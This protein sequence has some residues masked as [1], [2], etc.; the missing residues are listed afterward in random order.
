MNVFSFR[1]VARAVLATIF[2]AVL[3]TGCENTA[4]PAAKRP[5][6]PVIGVFL[7]KD[8]DVYISMVRTA[9][10]QAL[11]DWA[12]IILCAAQSDQLL[13]NEQIDRLL[14]E[15]MDGLLVNLVDI[16]AASFVVDKAKKRGVPVVFFN[17]E[18]DPAAIKVYDKACFVGTTPADAGKMQ[19]DIIKRL[20][21]DHPEYD[22][23]KDGQCQ[24][25]MLQANPDNPEAVARTEYSVRQARE[26]GVAM[27]QV[28][29]TL[30]CDWSQAE[31]LRAVRY[32][33]A[34]LED[35]VELVIANNDSMALGAA[36]AL[37]ERGYNREGG[38]PAKFIP[39][40]GVDAT[41]QAVEAIDKG[42]MSATV[43]QDAALM[44]EVIATFIL[45]AVAGKSFIEGTSWTWDATGIAVRVPY[46]PYESGR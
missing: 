36:E 46:S 39:V 37:A 40:V 35:V 29:E 11:E 19:G 45:N 6:K 5:D 16:Q 42:A 38:D 10:E 27:S 12:T 23:N 43:K 7:Y 9:L 21:D 24:Y 33:L 8:D 26:L 2:C 1:G 31:A 14:Q 44:G 20:W 25:I 41:P 17:R 3:L 34:S 30:M 28:G 22:R 4:P 18:P 15:G 32:A 13:Q